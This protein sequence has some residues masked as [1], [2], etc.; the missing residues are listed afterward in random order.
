[1]LLF[2]VQTGLK[3]W[4]LW[5]SALSLL[6]KHHKWNQDIGS[7]YARICIA[8]ESGSRSE[9]EWKAGSGSIRAS[10]L[11][12][13]AWRLKMEVWRVCRPVVADSHQLD[14]EQDPDPHWNE[15]LDPDPH[16]SEKLVTGSWS[17]WKWCGSESLNSTLN[18]I[19]QL[20]TA[21]SKP[22]LVFR[23]KL[24]KFILSPDPGPPVSM[25]KQRILT[26]H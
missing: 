14:E 13:Y 12:I 1:M 9:L 22:Y 24:R 5:R 6:G 2:P 16:K 17:A 21:P 8:F 4:T 23:N 25:T 11:K 15:K 18:R 3:D 20:W 10:R 7:G 26:L 19:Y